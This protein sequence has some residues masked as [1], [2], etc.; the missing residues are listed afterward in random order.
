MI[1]KRKT[2][3]SRGAVEHRPTTHDERATRIL[4]VVRRIPRGCVSTYGT[5]A[6]QAGLPRCARLVG[7]VLS[8]RGEDAPW[9]RVVNA[10]GR[11]SF[12][13]GSD[14]YRRQRA[15]LEEEGVVFR[16]EKIDLQR[17]GW[18]QRDRLDDAVWGAVLQERD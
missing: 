11:L 9:Q 13:L 14:S 3:G 10:S 12:A 6:E 18:P 15:Y 5:V 8:Q 17:F 4:S 1:R 7:A 2:G 16:G